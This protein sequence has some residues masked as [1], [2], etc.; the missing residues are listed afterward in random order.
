MDIMVTL[1]Y[2]WGGSVAMLLPSIRGSYEYVNHAKYFTNEAYVPFLGLILSTVVISWF[3]I[4][5]N[6]LSMNSDSEWL[7]FFLL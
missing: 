4:I 3:I 1:L 7:A 6:Y 2:L 5:S